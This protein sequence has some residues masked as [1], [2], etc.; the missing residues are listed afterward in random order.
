MDFVIREFFIDW[1][2]KL[3]TGIDEV[4]DGEK[5][6]GID[7]DQGNPIGSY[8]DDIRLVTTRFP[9]LPFV[10]GLLFCSIGTRAEK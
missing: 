7:I 10:F 1:P 8:T 4:M 6:D 9:F 2:G 3:G 5:I